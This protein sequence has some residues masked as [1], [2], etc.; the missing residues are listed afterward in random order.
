MPVLRTLLKVVIST[1]VILVLLYLAFVG[2]IIFIFS[3]SSIE[4]TIPQEVGGSLVSHGEEWM[5]HQSYGYDVE[6]EIMPDGESQYYKIGSSSCSGCQFNTNKQILKIEN[7]YVLIAGDRHKGDKLFAS[8]DLKVWK[9]FIF[10]R[11]RLISTC[12]INGSFREN[13]WPDE[14]HLD[15]MQEHRALWKRR[16]GTGKE[17]KSEV[18]SFT[19]KLDWDNTRIECLTSEK[20]LGVSSSK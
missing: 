2:F 8:K 1:I 4:H 18:L 15:N 13:S 3:G 7:L 10:N 12:S 16:V 14:V 17:P 6:Y 19:F 5:D 11:E 20:I 9:E